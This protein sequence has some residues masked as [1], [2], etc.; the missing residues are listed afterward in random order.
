M[1]SAVMGAY[2]SMI[3]PFVVTTFIIS[4]T[5]KRNPLNTQFP[6]YQ[7]IYMRE[8]YSAILLMV[9]MMEEEEEEEERK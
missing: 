8:Y 1:H 2:S 3:P 5:S 7:Y 4:S 9:V 6:M